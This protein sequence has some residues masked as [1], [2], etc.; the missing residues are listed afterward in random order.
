MRRSRT[1]PVP[2][3]SGKHTGPLSHNRGWEALG[4]RTLSQR[5]S[6]LDRCHARGS[7]ERAREARLR[8]KS[9]I[10]SNFSEGSASRCNHCLR[11]LQPPSADIATWRHSHGA[12]KCAGE[13]KD[14]KTRDI[15]E[16]GDGDVFAEMFFDVA[17]HTTQPRRIKMMGGNRGGPT[18]SPIAVFLMRLNF[19]G[20]ELDCNVQGHV[21]FFL[22]SVCRSLLPSL[23][24]IFCF[25]M[26]SIDR[27]T[28]HTP[29][30]TLACEDELRG[31]RGG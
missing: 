21:G 26:R 10:K 3:H 16:V 9:A 6:I 5:S 19:V 17:E 22:I 15:S 4:R 27:L 29:K 23:L 2:E 20:R 18:R 11:E 1:W 25:D 7:P 13:M 31:S 12:G 14:A 30:S 28:R 8:G 24:P